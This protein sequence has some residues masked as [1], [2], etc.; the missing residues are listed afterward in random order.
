MEL[1]APR[2]AVC[3]VAAAPWAMP[4][5]TAEQPLDFATVY[6]RNWKNVARWVRALGGPDADLDDLTQDV[7]LVVR[8]KLDAFDG[9]NLSGWLYRIAA[10]TVSDH[11]R[12]AWFRKL[13]L[14]PREVILDEIAEEGPSPERTLERAEARR[15]LHKL[16][17]RMSDKRR[18]ALVLYEIE[19][20]S[21]DEIAALEGIPVATVRTRL[22]HARKEF[23]VL[24][25]K[26]DRTGRP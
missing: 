4:A 21:S 9:R 26:H 7:F 10:R 15:A 17:R 22:H 3:A 6:D 14:R 25:S 13:F 19:G 2:F 16:L 5:V 1:E 8:R 24:L 23:L 20:Y 18:T 11:R 12:R